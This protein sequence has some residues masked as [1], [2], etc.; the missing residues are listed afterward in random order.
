MARKVA[1]GVNKR[2]SSKQR[3]LNLDSG[4]SSRNE[5]NFQIGRGALNSDRLRELID[6]PTV[7]YVAAG[8]ATAILSRLATNLS[9]KY[10]ELSRLLKENVDSF[11]GRIGQFRTGMGGGQERESRV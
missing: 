11:E 4:E 1:N 10:P 5:S 9:E 8:F 6:N 3:N 2:Q 7:R